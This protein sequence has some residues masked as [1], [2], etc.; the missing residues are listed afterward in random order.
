[1]VVALYFGWKVGVFIKWSGIGPTRRLVQSGPR[2]CPFLFSVFGPVRVRT[3]PDRL[4]LIFPP[5]LSR[6]TR[7]LQTC[8][9]ALSSSSFTFLISHF[10]SSLLHS[11]FSFV[12]STSHL[13]LLSA[14][15]LV[16]PRSAFALYPPSRVCASPGG[17]DLLCLSSLRDYLELDLLSSPPSGGRR[18]PPS[19]VSCNLVE[20]CLELFI[21]LLGVA[22]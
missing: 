18:L 12:H 22:I 4:E 8:S 17:P 15:S 13:L 2:S 21:I 11:P 5:L 20:V 19:G 16:S 3:G 7:C 10:F 14:Q 9:V 1:M 6:L